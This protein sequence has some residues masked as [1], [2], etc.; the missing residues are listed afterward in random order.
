MALLAAL[1]VVRDMTCWLSLSEI[2]GCC[3]GST[4]VSGSR[5]PSWLKIFKAR[6]CCGNDDEGIPSVF[7]GSHSGCE[8]DEQPKHLVPVTSFKKFI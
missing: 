2:Y 8:L 1:V 3:C 5:K 4:M 6:N 7:D